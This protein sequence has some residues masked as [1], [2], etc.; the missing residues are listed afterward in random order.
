V[1]DGVLALVG[2]AGKRWQMLPQR[3]WSD[4][5]ILHTTRPPGRASQAALASRFVRS[6]A[7]SLGIHCAPTHLANAN[8]GYIRDIRLHSA[9]TYV[10]Y[11]VQGV[12]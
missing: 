9:L 1:R 3:E 4:A 2:E 8:L 12:C 7:L 6:R 11:T 5:S 10:A